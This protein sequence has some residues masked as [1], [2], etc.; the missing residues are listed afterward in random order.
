MPPTYANILPT[1]Q[2]PASQAFGG[3]TSPYSLISA[4]TVNATVVKATPGNIYDLIVSNVNAA[5]RYLKLYDKATAPAET[6]TPVMRILLPGNATGAGIAKSF[7]SGLAFNS[8]ISFRLTTGVADNDTGA[9]AA[10][11]LLVNI[12]YR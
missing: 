12:A 11:E 2:V 6:D 8:G 3:S 1:N 7:V 10:N 9:V 5:A 4:G